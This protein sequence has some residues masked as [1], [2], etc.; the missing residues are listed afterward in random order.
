L[1]LKGLEHHVFRLALLVVVLTLA[2]GQTATLVCRAWCDSQGTATA[3]CEH[4]RQQR[5]STSTLS[6]EDGCT[7]GAASTAVVRE[8]MRRTAPDRGPVAV[9]QP[10]QAACSRTHIG[11]AHSAVRQASLDARP[12]VLALRI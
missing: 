1:P 7:D 8:N 2:T 11:V 12:L 10:F 5:T 4:P 6:A 3:A 9:V